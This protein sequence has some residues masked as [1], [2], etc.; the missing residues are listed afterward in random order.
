MPPSRVRVR[1][2][3]SA[4]QICKSSTLRVACIVSISS[5][6][7][8]IFQLLAA[9]TG[10]ELFSC[11]KW[12]L[13]RLLSRLQSETHLQVTYYWLSALSSGCWYHCQYSRQ[14][15][16]TNEREIKINCKGDFQIHWLR[17]SVCGKNAAMN[18]NTKKPNQHTV[19]QRL[20]TTS[21]IRPPCYYDQFFV[22]WKKL[23]VHSFI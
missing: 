9:E 2:I 16:D 15:Q 5:K 8:A 13:C 7:K 1:L 20:T 14:L 11:W 12:L 3:T 17:T 4:P 22:P 6:R 10:K 23:K 19:E 18:G 21:S